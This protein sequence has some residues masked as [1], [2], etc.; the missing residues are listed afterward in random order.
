MLP[1][2]HVCKIFSTVLFNSYIIAVH[3]F[4][5]SLL[6]SVFLIDPLAAAD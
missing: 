4:D 2:V 5:F 6:L 1:Y 3:V